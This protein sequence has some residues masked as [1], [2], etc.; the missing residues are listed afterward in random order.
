MGGK[1]KRRRRDGWRG[2][3]GFG[4]VVIVIGSESG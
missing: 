3:F 4:I 1:G 2:G